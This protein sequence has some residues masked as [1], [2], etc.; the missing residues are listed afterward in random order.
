MKHTPEKCGQCGVVIAPKQHPHDDP[1]YKSNRNLSSMGP[2]WT[3][4]CA[5]WGP[6]DGS[7]FNPFELDSVP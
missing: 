4:V 5:T 3:C 7:T 1:A 2:Q 6:A